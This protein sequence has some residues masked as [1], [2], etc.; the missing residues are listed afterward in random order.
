V[1]PD[2]EYEI[3]EAFVMADTSADVT[4]LGGREYGRGYWTSRGSRAT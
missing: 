1:V 2:S 4:Y 3:R